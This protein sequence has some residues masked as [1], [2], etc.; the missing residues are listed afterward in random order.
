VEKGGR[1]VTEW[2]CE[3]D[4]TFTADLEDG[5][6]WEPRMKAASRSWKRQGNSFSYRTSS[7]E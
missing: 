7:K 1:R 5:R 6:G 4:V 3:Q 2:K